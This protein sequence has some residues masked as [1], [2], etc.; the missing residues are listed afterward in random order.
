M[1]GKGLSYTHFAFVERE[2]E[3]KI[4]KKYLNVW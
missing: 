1:F 3:E 2:K 4:K